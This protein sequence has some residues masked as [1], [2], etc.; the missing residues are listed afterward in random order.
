MR[1]IS[2]EGTLGNCLRMFSILKDAPKLKKKKKFKIKVYLK[3]SF[4]LLLCNSFMMVFTRD[5]LFCFFSSIYFFFLIF[6]FIF[7]KNVKK[8][9]NL[10]NLKNLKIYLIIFYLFYLKK[11]FF[12]CFL[13]DL[14]NH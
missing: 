6:F 12:F 3:I 9:K 14:P 10:K 11:L 1:I 2:S 13:L 7:F 8:K 4:E 5:G